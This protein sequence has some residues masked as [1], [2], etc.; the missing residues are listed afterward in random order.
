MTRA[1]D[2]KEEVGPARTWAA[3]PKGEASEARTWLE[4]QEGRRAKQGHGSKNQEGRRAKQGH[5][6]KNQEGR[7]AKQGHGS[8]NQ[9]RTRTR[10]GLGW[11]TQAR[12]RT[13]RGAGSKIQRVGAADKDLDG[14]SGEAGRRDE[15]RG[16]RSCQRPAEIDVRAVLRRETTMPP[17]HAPWSRSLFQT[18]SYPALRL[19]SS[20]GM[21]SGR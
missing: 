21:G 9:R 4:N 14:R 17:W 2:S 19:T 10:Q 16:R 8:K 5:G 12:R 13:W 18:R 1:G 20:P 15:G 3:D 11:A 6:S 7:R